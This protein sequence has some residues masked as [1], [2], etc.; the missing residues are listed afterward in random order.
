MS[1]SIT[2]FFKPVQTKGE[3]NENAQQKIEFLIQLA[4]AFSQMTYQSLY[5]V[6]YSKRSFIYVSD[7]PIFLCGTKPE[8]VLKEGYMFYLRNIPEKDLEMLLQINKAGFAFFNQLPKEERFNY[9]ISYDF[10]LKQPKGDLMLINH[11]LKPLLLDQHGNPWIAL[12]LVSI[13]SNNKAGNIKFKNSELNKSYEFNIETNEW[14]EMETIA[15]NNREKNILM[16]SAQGL[17]MEQIASRLFLSADTIKF[18]KKNIFRK[19]NVKNITE[20]IAAA[21]E[22][23]LI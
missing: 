8:Q 23:A 3:L 12:C 19:L 9:F 2:D 15:L 1:I 13:S 17:T 7:N 22:L 18:H 5:I 10:H 16:L 20:A 6:D 4:K 11:K 21:M 14:Y